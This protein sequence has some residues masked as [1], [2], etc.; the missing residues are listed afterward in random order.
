VTNF[1]SRQTERHGLEVPL[2]GFGGDFVIKQNQNGFTPFV[3]GGIGITPLLSQLQDLNIAQLR[4]FWTLG[5]RDIGL[6][7]D[8]FKRFPTLSKST[9]LFLTGDESS[10]PEG[11]VAK[12]EEVIASGARFLKRRILAE[13]L[14]EVD[15]ED[16]YLC[17]A[18]GLRDS[19]LRWL[20]GKK[21]IYE[22]FNY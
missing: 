10:V 2:R 18:P 9:A 20:P 7:H 14:A 22:N 6:V 5:I 15:A 17:T 11:D 16:W 13:D 8:T 4:L 3:A 1:L 12:L 21:T 19:I